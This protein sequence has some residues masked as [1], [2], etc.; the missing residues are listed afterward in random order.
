LVAPRIAANV[1]NIARTCEAL[2]AELHLVGPLGFFLDEKHLKRSS[3]GYWQTL[4]PNFHKDATEFWGGFQ[5]G[6]LSQIFWATKRANSVYTDHVFGMDTCLIFGN[7]EEGV[8]DEFWSIK[9]KNFKGLPEVVP[10]AIPMTDTRC[11]NLATSVGIMGYEVAR[12]WRSQPTG[13]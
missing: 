11:L 13:V 8:P 4:R 10:C 2:S 6:L 1:G 9:A 12:Q 7:E 3:V 5:K